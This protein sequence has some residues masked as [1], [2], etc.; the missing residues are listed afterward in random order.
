MPASKTRMYQY[1]K[2]VSKLRSEVLFRVIF[3]RDQIK[4]EIIYLNTQEQLFNKGIDSEGVR[5]DAA[6]GFGYANV[7]KQ[8][9]A[10]KGQPTDRIT[11]KDTGEFYQ[12]FKVDVREGVITINAD[13]QKDDTNLFDEWGVD[14][15]GLTE[16]SI[17]RLKPLIIEN[18]KQY[19][20]ELLG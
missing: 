12:S 13:A 15:L 5:L 17:K 19:I 16:E 3:S 20:L 6:R 4:E 11:L 10:R 1:A 18:Y 8:I 7:T 9:K 14:I 2:R